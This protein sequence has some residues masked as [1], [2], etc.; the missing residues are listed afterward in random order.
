MAFA[1]VSLFI[2]IIV[3][4]LT[5]ELELKTK[6]KKVKSYSFLIFHREFLVFW[7]LCPT[8][9]GDLNEKN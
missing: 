6:S 2:Y 8:S 4:V 1:V 5:L 7:L 3:F 9:S